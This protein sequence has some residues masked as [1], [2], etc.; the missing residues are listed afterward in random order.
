MI[1]EPNIHLPTPPQAHV[2]V[3]ARSGLYYVHR[4]NSTVSTLD[5]TRLPCIDRPDRDVLIALLRYALDQ[6]TEEPA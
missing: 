1:A 2:G 3:P 6:L 4:D 5:I